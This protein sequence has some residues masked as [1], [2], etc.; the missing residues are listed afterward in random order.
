MYL[1]TK[2]HTNLSLLTDS[3]GEKPGGSC[4]F[5]QHLT[6]KFLLGTTAMYQHKKANQYIRVFYV[7]TSLKYRYAD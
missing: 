2:Y 4:V 5:S 1:S 3:V 6:S 7:H